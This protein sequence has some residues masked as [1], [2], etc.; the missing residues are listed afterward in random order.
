M[1]FSH[2]CIFFH[3]QI[4]S[5]TPKLHTSRSQSRFIVCC[6]C[7]RFALIFLSFVVYFGYVWFFF[8][9]SF[10]VQYSIFVVRSHVHNPMNMLIF[11]FHSVGFVITGAYCAHAIY[12]IVMLQNQTITFSR[13]AASFFFFLFDEIEVKW[14]HSYM[15]YFH[16]LSCPTIYVAWFCFCRIVVVVFF[17][18]NCSKWIKLLLQQITFEISMFDVN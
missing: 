1:H 3:I 16:L 17:V 7:F 12:Q 15:F 4:Q 9:R 10:L 18:S 5:V 8:L 13:C 14:K 2:V 11:T 6:S